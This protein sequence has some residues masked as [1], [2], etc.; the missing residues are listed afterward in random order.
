MIPEAMRHDD[1]KDINGLVCNKG[2]QGSLRAQQLWR[3][4]QST[5]N[6]KI[7]ISRGASLCQSQYSADQRPCFITLFSPIAADLVGTGDGRKRGRGLGNHT[8]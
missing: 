4:S 3:K 2:R 1:T 8:D 7:Q 6:R 5:P